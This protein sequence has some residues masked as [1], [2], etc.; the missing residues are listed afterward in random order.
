MHTH[1]DKRFVICVYCTA[2]MDITRL[3]SAILWLCTCVRAL[4]SDCTPL[5][6]HVLDQFDPRTVFGTN[7]EISSHQPP[8]R[9][10]SNI[11]PGRPLP[12]HAF[13][14]SQIKTTRPEPMVLWPYF[15]TMDAEGIAYDAFEF[16]RFIDPERTVYADGQSIWEEGRPWHRLL[17][18]GTNM[19]QKVSGPDG[20]PLGNFDGESGVRIGIEGSGE[21][22]LQDFGDLYG[23]FM[24]TGNG[25]SM[26]VPLVRGS[27]LLTHIFKNA[28]PVIRPYCLDNI[29]G[30]HHQF[31]CPLAPASS[32]GGS[33]YL[34]ATC[35]GSILKITLHNTRPIK[36]LGLIQWA[37][38]TASQYGAS[39]GMHNCNSQNC[40]LLDNGKQVEITI[41]N[42][43]GTMS[44]AI[45]Y[46]GH[47]LLPPDWVNN[48]NQVTCNVGKKRS[49]AEERPSAKE[50]RS[51]AKEERSI[52]DIAL[53]ATCDSGNNVEIRV[54][55]AGYKFATHLIQYAVEASNNWSN[56][57]PMRTCGSNC[58]RSGN[59]VIIRRH[60]PSSHIKLAINII[61]YETMPYSHWVSRPLELYCGSGHT[62]NYGGRGTIPTVH[63]TN[64]PPVTSAPHTQPP[65]HHTA[66]PHTTPQPH[67][68]HQTGGGTPLTAN[69]KF[70]LEMN[71][72]GNDLPHQ[73]RKF[74][75]YF[76]EEVTPHVHQSD[77]KI[78][79]SPRAG[80][81]YNGLVQ[82]AYLG[83]GPR[84][85]H[86]NDSVFDKY[87]GIYSYKPK[88]SF[89]VS[90]STNKAH[91]TFNWHPNNLHA[92]SPTASLL[93]LM[94][95]HHA[96]TLDNRYSYNVRDTVFGFKAYEGSS[97]DLPMDLPRASMAPD[98][99][100]V[101]RLTSQQKQD[102]VAAIDRDASNTYLDAICSHSDSYNV[103]KAIGMVARLASISR[104]FNTNHFTK[105]DTS[106]KN[107][108]EKWL[109]VQDTLSDM[110]KFR[111]DT[112]WGGLFLRATNGDLNFGVDY[113]FPYYNDHHFH[114]GYFIYAAAYYVKH[115]PQW[116]QSNKHKLYLLARD[117]SNPSPNDPYF[118][119]A[120]HKDIYTG[121]S[122]ASGLVPGTR[123]EESASE[124]LNCYH[125]VAALGEAF[126][127]KSLQH[128][129]QVMLAMELL[130]V[131]EYWQVRQHNRDHF[132]PIIQDTGVCGQI[133]EDSFYVYTLDWPCDPNRFPM[134][135]A[136][137]V[138]IQ[139]I[140]IT[141]VSK[142]W[143]D[144]EWA[145][146][147]K[148]SCTSAVH[149][150]QESSYSIADHNERSRTLSTGWAAFCL[151]AMA[152][153]DSTHQT[154]A[155]N[156]VRDKRPQQLVGGTGAASTLL[157]IYAST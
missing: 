3:V 143:V 96:Y 122:W 135:H 131:R 9:V 153:L 151:A 157:F 146:S 18:L 8:K 119:V 21:P 38:N 2:L 142:Y 94:M 58:V 63:H 92:T 121:F 104:E 59:L 23:N 108:L 53:H 74:V 36:D 85:G 33:G 50:E 87:A 57:P 62:V 34:S 115:Y 133:A 35:A 10:R 11:R 97:I 134:R 154:E 120:R 89:C 28:N 56:P 88:T 55:L 132:P 17:D 150:E 67:V 65:V 52:R 112:V 86:G 27:I 113:G 118:P 1:K 79:F 39:H 64:P 4:P 12:T 114:L 40:R 70:I 136:C 137:L 147:I 91:V 46:I 126:N 93:M 44:Y 49:S 82:I 139:I 78:T 149:P 111:Y 68:T 95:P 117:V 69:K 54:D 76:S 24:Y 152:P 90:E 101:S 109:R 130:S 129:G 48:P 81:N 125:G 26:E 84:G 30:E 14:T 145:S 45:N 5:E 148:H 123:Q 140:P 80:G 42:A 13:F 25:G 43:S 60:L 156:Y 19:F 20:N 99:G 155:A 77:N 138:G 127:D 29:N 100:A 22:E 107:C 141:S 7:N 73:T 16:K 6:D 66:A 31:K 98:S 116:G 15:A 106:I 105:L 51:S 102:I 72:Q 47:Y 41:P 103:G 75:L 71:E 110:W 128:A 32:D 83:A 124:S 61:G 37:A 144:K